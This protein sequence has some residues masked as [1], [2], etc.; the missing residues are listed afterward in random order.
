MILIETAVQ[1]AFD[2]TQEAHYFCAVLNSSPWR[3]VIV[4]TAVHGTGGFGSP[5]VLTKARIPRFKPADGVHRELVGL[6]EN[7][8]RATTGCDLASVREMEKRID[9]LAA[10][11]WGL[12]PAEL[13]EIQISLQDLA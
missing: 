9:E 5:N 8:H 2:T 4:S 3:F 13:K 7:A 10:Q 1:V 12:S 11:M 6:S